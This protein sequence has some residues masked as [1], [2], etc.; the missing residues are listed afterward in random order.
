IRA[1]HVKSQQTADAIA[2]ELATSFMFTGDPHFQD[3]YVDEIQKITAADLARVA[4]QYLVRERLITTA[5]L[6]AEFTGAAGYAKAED[7]LRA[8]AP[9]TQKSTTAP[10][11]QVITR[12]ELGNGIT[13]LHKRIST[14]PLVVMTMY[15]L[16]GVT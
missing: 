5:L 12:V 3:R 11:D 8:A 10:S 6:P 15:S 7:L 13:L 14:T 2:S 4:R 9:T 1:A 16:G